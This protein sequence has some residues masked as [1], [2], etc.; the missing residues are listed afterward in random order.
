[1]MIGSMSTRR[2][3]SV[4][5]GLTLASWSTVGVAVALFVQLAH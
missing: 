1:M 4:L 3:Y 5:A 2:R